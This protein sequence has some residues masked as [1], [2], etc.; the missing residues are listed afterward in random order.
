MY[1]NETMANISTV[2]VSTDLE[3]KYET[4]GYAYPCG[5][6][7]YYN[8]AVFVVSSLIFVA[9]VA[10]NYIVIYHLSTKKEFKNNTT[11]ACINL[12]AISDLM[13]LTVSYWEE[14]LAGYYFWDVMGLNN[15]QCTLYV[16]VGVSPFLLSCYSVSMLALVRY[17]VVVHPLKVSKLKI[18]K[19]I[20][21]LYIIATIVISSVIAVIGRVSLETMTCYD[22]IYDNGNLAYIIPPTVIGT[23]AFLLILHILKVRQ[24]RRSLSARTNNVRSSIR[25]INIVIYVIMSLFIVCQTPYI[26][27]DFAE[28]LEENSEF[29]IVFSEQFIK[30]L[31]SIGIVFHLLNHAVNPY[32]YFISYYYTKRGQ[33]RLVLA[34]RP[35]NIPVATCQ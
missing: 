29:N 31:L 6:D 17:H 24:L 35:L 1:S 34:S 10:G 16:I 4:S 23:I 33:D 27:Y 3:S 18:R 26:V 11:F 7:H 20:V 22:V 19:Y 15:V 2:N 13:S 30:I 28:V 25:K 5:N 21:V 8:C 12:L 9:G 32:V 14:M